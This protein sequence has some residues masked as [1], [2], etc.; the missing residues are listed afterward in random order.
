MIWHLSRNISY[1]FF[2][3]FFF[4][5]RT[6]LNI[7]VNVWGCHHQKWPKNFPR[8]EQLNIICYQQ[9]KSPPTSHSESYLWLLIAAYTL[10]DRFF[11]VC[12]CLWYV[13]SPCRSPPPAA[14]GQSLLW[15]F[16]A[17]GEAACLQKGP[18]RSPGK[19]ITELRHLNLNILC[20]YCN[21]KNSV[22][23]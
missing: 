15:F 13:F 21:V 14:S 5:Y 7:E 6:I 12:C 20:T 2:G 1:L 3:L 11:M 16:T 22:L 18:G 17:S 9:L 10:P 23:C 4:L 8:S 19:N